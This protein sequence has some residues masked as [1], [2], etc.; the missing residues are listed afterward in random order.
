MIAI[1][2]A[3]IGPF[4]LGVVT[5]RSA[6]RLEPRRAQVSID[7]AGSDPIP[8]IVAGIPI[9]LRDIRV[10][11]DRPN[12]MLNPT[13]CEN[14][15]ADAV[16]T[17]S[18][19]SF[20]NPA[21]DD[22]TRVPYPFQ[23]S[24]CSALQFQPRLSIDLKGG[25]ERGDFPQL[26]A[27]YRPRPGDANV[28]NAAVTLPKTVFL[29]QENIGRAC[30]RV[31]FAA[32]H[33]PSDSVYGSATAITP[34]LSEPLTGPVYLRSSNDVL[35][36]MVA[37]LKGGGVEVEVVGRID[38]PHGGLRGRFEVLPDAPVTKFVLKLKGGKHGVIQLSRNICAQ[39]QF[40]AARMIGQ[41]NVG[42]RWTPLLHAVCNGQNGK[43]GRR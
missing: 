33:C 30:T 29:A 20:G 41:N 27:T 6:I 37:D 21:D 3:N 28:G 8:H 34:L 1:N 39:P 14:Y 32:D 17:G 40:A 9:H 4:D 25:T 23:V 24:N 35:P 2:S 36:E 43:R 10:Y 31:Q 7:S 19:V 15:S 13:S 18:G 42:V 22:T 38:A 12:F 16:M 26:T 11:I 5:V